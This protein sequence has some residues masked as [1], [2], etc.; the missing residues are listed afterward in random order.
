MMYIRDGIAYA[1]ELEPQVKIVGVKPLDGYE[2]WLRFS[3][4]EERLYDLKPLFDYPAFAPLKDL[5]VFKE[6][7]L[8][9]GVPTW[10]DGS[11]D[12]APESLYKC[13][14]PTKAGV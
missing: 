5:D 14:V 11:I 4:N 3:N 10:L 6:V 7:Y 8:D 2:L 9:Y 12:I 1:G 13:S